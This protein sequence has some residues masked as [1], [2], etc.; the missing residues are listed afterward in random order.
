[1]RRLALV[2][3]AFIAAGPARAHGYVSTD[4]PKDGAV[5]G[6]LRLDERAETM[7]RNPSSRIES[8]G[9]MKKSKPRADNPSRLIDALIRAAVRLN[10]G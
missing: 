4:L 10:R 7:T 2:F 8:T 9:P 3:L 6:A 5:L 1:M